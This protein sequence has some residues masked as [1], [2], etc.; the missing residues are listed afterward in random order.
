MIPRAHPAFF[1]IFVVIVAPVGAAVLV[2]ALLLFGVPPHLVFAPG[3]AVMS[4][5]EVCGVRAPNAVGVVSTV[6]L[7]W[8][9]F[10]A[11]GTAWERRRNRSAS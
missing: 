8:L 2:T 4:F 5:L 3:R 9:V 7:W 10:V 6:T 1:V 11:V